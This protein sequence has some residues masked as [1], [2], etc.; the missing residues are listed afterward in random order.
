MHSQ[1]L[2]EKLKGF[3]ERVRENCPKLGNF[4]RFSVLNEFMELAGVVKELRLN[5]DA[6]FCYELPRDCFLRL[7]FL[8]EAS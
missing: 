7:V 4:V 5:L 1:D 2:E 8:D 3:V 6:E